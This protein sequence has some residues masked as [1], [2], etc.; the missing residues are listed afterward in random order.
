MKTTLMTS[1]KR[2][3]TVD[4]KRAKEIERGCNDA[5]MNR[6]KQAVE[7]MAIDMQHHAGVAVIPHEWVDYCRELIAGWRDE[8]HMRNR[9][10]F[11][12]ITNSVCPAQRCQKRPSWCSVDLEHPE[13]FALPNCHCKDNPHICWQK[14]GKGEE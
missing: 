4:E 8:F 7:T 5:M 11:N 3:A 12:L 13:S 1:R 10:I 2:R 14:V 6:V 9:L